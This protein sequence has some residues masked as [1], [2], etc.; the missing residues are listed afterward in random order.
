MS[1]YPKLWGRSSAVGEAKVRQLQ[2]VGTPWLRAS[3]PGFVAEKQSKLSNVKTHDERGIWFIAEPSEV[4]ILGSTA[5]RVSWGAPLSVSGVPI[6]PP[7]GTPGGDNPCWIVRSTPVAKPKTRRGRSTNYGLRTWTHGKTVLSWR[8]P[9]SRWF[10]EVEFLRRNLT[11]TG[12]L[13][14][15]VSEGKDMSKVYFDGTP[16]AHWQDKPLA[17]QWFLSYFADGLIFQGEAVLLN[18]ADFEIAGVVCGAAMY[19]GALHFITRTR[20][21]SPVYR[22][23]S[24]QLDPTE[25]PELLHTST[26]LS[27]SFPMSGWYFSG[28]TGEATCTLARASEDFS[29]INSLSA[30]GAQDRRDE[31]W[32]GSYRVDSGFSFTQGFKL[33]TAAKGT[34][35]ESWVPS[36]TGGNGTWEIVYPRAEIPLYR[37]FR[38]DEAREFS[39]F[40]PAYREYG[41]D[42]SSETTDILT[43]TS[44]RGVSTTP[45]GGLLAL[46]VNG[47][48][49]IEL[50]APVREESVTYEY[51]YNP[52]YATTGAATRHYKDTSAF[53]L[54]V[55]AR[56]D[57][58]I[59]KT[60]VG[61]ETSSAAGIATGGAISGSGTFTDSSSELLAGQGPTMA[62]RQVDTTYPAGDH[63]VSWPRGHYTGWNPLVAPAPITLAPPSP[64]GR[65]DYLSVSGAEKAG[66]Y[67]AGG[68]DWQGHVFAVVSD[69]KRRNEQVKPALFGPENLDIRGLH[70]ISISEVSRG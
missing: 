68:V 70:N 10:D 20:L 3:G 12:A 22:A 5:A 23:Y 60:Q 11:L 17:Q 26:A 66:N 7:L 13:A 58:V 67:L 6:N 18:I 30:M 53:L 57:L 2:K 34:Y 55:D 8:G 41:S 42:D 52:P 43:Q 61:E 48:V 16:A 69:G 28:T 63:V 62:L 32:F 33:S 15:D 14:F 31:T 9:A 37:D 21:L 25:P 50:E 4:V 47:S 36:D 45:D 65:F 40:T 46:A 54:F 56:S 27:N 1:K 29:S 24:W 19:E 51:Q 59:L 49:L 35:V 38:G 39:M 64:F 44:S